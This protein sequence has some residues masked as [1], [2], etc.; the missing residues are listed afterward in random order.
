VVPYHV[1]HK[2]ARIFG[3]DLVPCLMNKKRITAI[4]VY[5]IK[6]LGGVPMKSARVM[7]KGLEW[8]RRWMLVDENNQFM[9]QRVFPTMALFK[10]AVN[11]EHLSVSFN[12]DLLQVPLQHEIGNMFEASVWNDKVMVGEVSKVFSD[13]FSARLGVSCRL[14]SFPEINPRPV[15]PNFAVNEDQVSLADAYPFLIIGE[16]SLR[17]L[18]SRLDEPVP[19]NRF[20]PNLVFSGGEPYEEDRW[21]NLRVG[22]NRFRGAKPCA[23]CALTTVNQETAI[24]GTEPLATLSK[25]RKEGNKVLFGENLIALDYKEI[26]INDEIILD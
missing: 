14:V 3:L 20:R 1:M 6:S 9:T 12:H 18:N 2:L 25:Y 21:K 22:I 17:D 19:M 5:P 8:D 24:K 16:A 15:D 7:P 10:L 26:A 11:S 4:W 23:R 13:W